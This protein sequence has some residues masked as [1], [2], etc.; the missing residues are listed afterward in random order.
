MRRWLLVLVSLFAG[1]GLRADV[2]HVV[3]KI[4]LAGVVS[5]LNETTL[6]TGLEYETSAAPVKSGWIFVYW[7]T[8]Q[9]SDP[10]V[11][12][13]AWGR[14]Y[15]QAKYTLYQDVELTANYVSA[16]EDS[17]GDGIADGY[18]IYWY[19]DL[20]E[21]PKSDTDGDGLTFEQE[22]AAGTNP[23]FADEDV[24][25]GIVYADGPVILYNPNGYA[26][27]ILRS[28]P[29]GEL[30]ASETNYL[31][32]GVVTNS[33]ALSVTGSTFAYWTLGGE[34]ACDAWGRALDSVEIAPNATSILEVVAHAVAD[35]DAR[36]SWYWYGRGDVGMDEDTDGDG[37]TFEQEL[38]AGT[39]PLFADEDVAGGIVYAD[40]DVME[41]NLQPYEQCV[42]AVVDEVFE[43]LFTS[44]YAEQDGMS[45]GANARPYVM[46][47]DGDGLFDLVIVSDEDYVVYRNR[48][49]AGNP[50]FVEDVGAETNGLDLAQ[51]DVCALE[52]LTLDVEPVGAVSC[53]FGDVDL[54]GVEDLL[55]SDEDGRI[56]FYKGQG[57]AS[58]VLQH[59]VWGGSYEGFAEGLRIAL[60]DWDGDGDMDLIGGLA[61]GRLILLRDPR[62]GRPTNVEALSGASSI[63]LTWDP[64]GDSRVR[65]YR[66][67]RA[68]AEDGDFAKCA[69]PTLPTYRDV[70]DVGEYWYRVT[71]LTRF[72]RSGNSV[73][74]ETESLPTDARRAE[75]G[76]VELGVRDAAGFAG[77]E[78]EVL[79]SVENAMG[80]SGKGLEVDVTF[81]KAVLSLTG[82]Q[83]TGLSE[84]L[85]MTYE[86]T[87]G[88]AV[89]R[90]TDGEIAA[91][92]GKLFA[93]EFAIDESAAGT[94]T[95]AIVSASL[96]SVRGREVAIRLP[97]EG[98][99]TI[100]A[101]EE[102]VLPEVSFVL[103][104]TNVTSGAAFE[105]PISLVS[106]GDVPRAGASFDVV[107]DTNVLSFARAE[108]GVE[109]AA[110]L[111]HFEG[112][113]S[114]VWGAGT[115]ELGVLNF[116]AAA[117]EDVAFTVVTVTNVVMASRV[118]NV[119]AAE[120][121]IFPKVE[122]GGDDGEG[123]GTE[124]DPSKYGY[125]FASFKL[126]AA[127][128]KIGETV[129]VP[130]IVRPWRDVTWD[131]FVAK[132][133]YDARC[134]EPVGVI[135]LKGEFEFAAVDGVLTIRGVSGKLAA[136]R[137]GLLGLLAQEYEVLTIRFYLREQYAERVTALGFMPGA[138]S[139]QLA[140][141]EGGKAY[142]PV[143]IAGG[144]AIDFTRPKDD[145]R[146]VPPYSRGDMNGDG[147]LDG[148]D[149]KRMDE[150]ADG[151]PGGGGGR[152]DRGRAERAGDYNGDGRIDHGDMH[153]MRKDFDEKGVRR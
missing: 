121:G 126:G 5:E 113:A 95:V 58:Y 107:Y 46:D 114:G 22:L 139:I 49:S 94:T 100:E 131:G 4:N 148:D 26:P 116:V 1:F 27:Y 12:R 122:E 132:I 123:E 41:V 120:I 138:A 104:D 67:Y 68:T 102:P 133:G 56:W 153:L 140:L 2:V 118:E 85:D 136:R 78:V 73:A 51:G 80:L 54:D 10:L 69:T 42:G 11:A 127:R 40:G 64:N 115:N 45:F 57:E 28:E 86:A 35:E 43:P 23:L 90:A 124:T 50:C 141:A 31:A 91:G 109:S 6:E 81:D 65:G 66:V 37:L 96:K 33:A 137:L 17:D 19:G 60:V 24:A 145:K 99:V 79:L 55:V 151:R 25:G 36:Q 75:V 135:G 29:E 70:V 59:K 47:L 76:R 44:F 117:V 13:D 146:I 144:V 103:G 112:G 34:R 105:V 98:V 147:R 97:V 39:N 149:Y 142:T 143:R 77:R 134:V 106:A 129:E 150:W 32:P 52:G 21:T 16:A 61:D 88:G 92:S 20:D 111:I 30:F 71:S 48:G 84:G 83:A 74:T 130:L 53:T 82:V 62:A 9:A 101:F 87:D 15:E 38:A 110:G 108:G 8:S 93:L 119:D 72:Y 7:S 152:E 14:A 125:S 89:I 3:E 63:L 128:G 18:E